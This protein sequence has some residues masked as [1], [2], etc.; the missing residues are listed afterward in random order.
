MLPKSKVLSGKIVF[1]DNL[2][3]AYGNAK[4]RAAEAGRI[5]TMPDLAGAKTDAGSY[6][7]LWTN[8][9]TSNSGEFYGLSRGGV[10]IVVVCHGLDKILENPEIMTR[11]AIKFMGDNRINLNAD[12]FYKLENG[13]FGKVEILEKK[14]ILGMRGYPSSVLSYAQAM[15][16]PLLRA[17]LGEHT[18]RF[19]AKH[20]QITQEESGNDFILVNGHDYT[21]IAEKR[22]FS[23]R[24]LA[25]TQLCNNTRGGKDQGKTSVSSE[26]YFSDLGSCGR[27]VV[28]RGQKGN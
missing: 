11:S 18:D 22:L 9:L 12:E 7:A 15:E 4:K 24:L 3:K 28:I 20:K 10:E 6:D 2:L 26:I 14:N 25:M 21:S 16:E 8:Y 19:L 23:G 13:E 5:A 27:F 17:R 1:N